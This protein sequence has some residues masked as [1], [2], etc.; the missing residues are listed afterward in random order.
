MLLKHST[1]DSSLQ[2]KDLFK[3]AGTLSCST[4]S[5]LCHY[6]NFMTSLFVFFICKLLLHYWLYKYIFLIVGFKMELLSIVNAS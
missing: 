2:F 5:L 4:F 3:H 6:Q 1:Q